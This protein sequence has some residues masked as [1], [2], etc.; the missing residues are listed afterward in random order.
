[1]G[2]RPYG[3]AVDYLILRITLRI[4]YFPM[5][6][7]KTL[8][9]KPAEVFKPGANLADGKCHGEIKI[10][11]VAVIECITLGIADTVGVVTDRAGRPLIND[12][13]FVLGKTL[14]RQ[15]AFPAVAFI[16]QGIF[17]SAF[18]R[19][20]ESCIV[21]FQQ[22]LVDGTV[23]ALRSIGII[24][25]M[26]IGAGYYAEYGIRLQQARHIGV[27][28]G[29][30]HRVKR[31]ISG[32]EF[33]A[34]VELRYLPGDGQGCEHVVVG[35]ALIAYFIQALH[36][37]RPAAAG[38]YP[39]YPPVGAGYGV[40]TRGCIAIC[41][42]GVMTILALNVAGYA[43]HR[44]TLGG[45]VQTHKILYGVPE[46]FRN[47]G[48][49]IQKR[50]IAVVAHQAIVL[51]KYMLQKPLGPGCRVGA[52]AIFAAVFRYGL[53]VRVRPGICTK[54]IPAGIGLGM[55]AG[56]PAY[57]RMAGIAEL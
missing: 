9:G 5:T 51:F 11:K 31:R 56:R 39:G 35:V 7:Q 33:Q 17:G 49:D 54:A 32:I 13:L 25:I 43:S 3:S 12:V 10:D 38:V 41:L 36:P 23:R 6:S 19:E 22:I 50:H 15:N 44:K 37:G 45:I 27:Q 30:H 57:L 48:F 29:C 8:S 2:H 34:G 26:A 52:V 28:P 55:R 14:I 40:R 47:F 16:T 18:R 21:S 4:M 53:K 42:V 24:G 1:M 20:I 46:P